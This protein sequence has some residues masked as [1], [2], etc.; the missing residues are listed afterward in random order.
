MTDRLSEW[1]QRKVDKDLSLFSAML[2]TMGHNQTK[3][4]R[5]NRPAKVILDII[6]LVSL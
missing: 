6:R 3:Y 5:L 1:Q 4:T 2:S